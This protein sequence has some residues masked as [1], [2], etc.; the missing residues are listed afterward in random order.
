MA[1]V[2]AEAAIGGFEAL[3]EARQRTRADG[4]MRADFHMAAPDRAGDNAQALA[5]VGLGNP[6]QIVR[7]QFAKPPVNLAD[8]LLC[9]CPSLQAARVDPFL[10]GDVGFRLELQIALVRIDAV[11]V[12]E[13][14]L[15]VD[16]MGVVAFDQVAVIAVHRPD[17]IGQRREQALRQA[18]PET[19]RA[20]REFERKVGERAAVARALAG[21]QRLHHAEVFARIFDRGRWNVRPYVRIRIIHGLSNT[22]GLRSH[23]ASLWPF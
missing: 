2:S 13:R 16:R 20:G 1:S 23:P 19:R 18:A 7:Q 11:I 9:G 3:K 8:P 14:P 15:D 17:Q 12:P 22:M 4:G 21:E 6:E 10:D 5:R